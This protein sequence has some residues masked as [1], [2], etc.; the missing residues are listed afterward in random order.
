MAGTAN[1]RPVRVCIDSGANLSIMSADALTDDIPTHAWV[2]REDIEVLNRRIRLTLA[3][4][5]DVT[6][7]T[8]NVRLEDTVVTEL[9]SGIDLILGSEWRRVANVDVTSHTS[10]NVT[11]V[12]V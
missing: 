4:T 11:I 6:L 8:T 2:S 7:G 5:L 3:G 9:P 12:P 10:N 1:N